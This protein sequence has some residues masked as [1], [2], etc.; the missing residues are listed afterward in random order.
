MGNRWQ[1][2]ALLQLTFPLW[3]CLHILKLFPPNTNF[4]F[5]N[6]TT[7]RPTDKSTD[8]WNM[9]GEDGRGSLWADSS[10]WDDRVLLALLYAL[11]IKLWLEGTLSKRLMR[12]RQTENKSDLAGVRGRA[13]S[14]SWD[15]LM[16]VVRVRL[17]P[18]GSKQGLHCK[19]CF[20][21]WKAAKG[22]CVLECRLIIY[23]DVSSSVCTL[24]QILT[25]FI[26]M[27]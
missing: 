7:R 25:A 19:G 18:K 22:K 4:P 12:G 2:T 24:N 14:F 27:W 20:E 10:C 8:G 16:V 3:A 15:A 21:I 9:D 13:P 6:K 11:I 23:V 17:A 5:W 1:Q 26:S